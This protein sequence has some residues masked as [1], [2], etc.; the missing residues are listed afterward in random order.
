M[1]R[2]ILEHESLGR[3]QR[4]RVHLRHQFADFPEPFAGVLNDALLWGWLV[5]PFPLGRPLKPAAVIAPLPKR[6]VVYPAK[7][8]GRIP[9][10]QV[11]LVFAVELI[12]AQSIRLSF[13][14]GLASYKPNL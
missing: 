2:V 3:N 7:I 13:C 9:C 11:G 4:A 12:D 5:A 1:V 6:F 10:R 8:A 14:E